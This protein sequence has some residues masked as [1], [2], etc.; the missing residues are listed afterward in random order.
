MRMRS[1][2]AAPTFPRFNA[3][4]PLPQV[5]DEVV[6]VWPGSAGIVAMDGG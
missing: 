2:F 3:L 1:Q 5:W 4:D 6:E